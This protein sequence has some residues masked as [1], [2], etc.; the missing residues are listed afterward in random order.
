MKPYFEDAGVTIYHGDYRDILPALEPVDLVLTDPPYGLGFRGEQWDSEIPLWLSAAREKAPIVAFTTA[1]TTMWK[2]PEPDWILCWHR[3]AANSRTA[4]GG[5]NHWTPV[6]VYGRGGPSPDTLTL[7]AIANA[8]KR[9]YWHPSPKPLKLLLWL[10]A[11]WPNA[12]TILD[13]FMGSGTTLAA[14]RD[15]G[16]EG[17]GIEIEEKYCEMAALR[18]LGVTP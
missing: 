17:I 7:H 18:L 3:Q 15:L 1:P 5:F 16:R 12:Q 11:A 14:A 2:Y 8:Q 6:L 13:P 10:V 9:G 4:Y